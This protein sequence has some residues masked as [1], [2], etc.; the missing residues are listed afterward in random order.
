MKIDNNFR[1]SVD[2]V[3]EEIRRKRDIAQL[4]END[5]CVISASLESHGGS[6]QSTAANHNDC[7]E[8]D[9]EEFSLVQM[10]HKADALAR[11]LVSLNQ[12]IARD[13]FERTTQS[14]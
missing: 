8:D 2:F 4:Q 12:E 6:V 10:E 14:I 5:D 13:T 9:A 3:N 7:L 11:L 1:H